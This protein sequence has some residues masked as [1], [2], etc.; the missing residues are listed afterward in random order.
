MD[1]HF[2]SLLTWYGL[3][4]LS[5]RLFLHFIIYCIPLLE[6]VGSKGSGLQW[7]HLYLIDRTF[8][9]MIGN[10]SSSSSPVKCGIPQGSILEPLLFSLYMLPLGLIFKK[11][12]IYSIS[13]HCYAYDSYDF[14]FLT[15]VQCWL[16][17]VKNLGA[18]MDSSLSF[19]KQIGIMWWEVV[20]TNSEI[21][22]N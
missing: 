21:F 7:F 15:Q 11:I 13:Y 16:S 8:S 6:V 4:Q 18:V 22:Q 17:E 14:L 12:Y 5:N 19:N 2:P 3:L 1:C 20:F 10:C 9:V